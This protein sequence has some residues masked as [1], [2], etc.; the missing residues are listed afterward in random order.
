MGETM[1]RFFA[2]LLISSLAFPN[3]QAASKKPTPQPTIKIST[4][5]VKPK[6]S[7][8]PSAKPSAKASAKPSPRSTTTKKASAAPT[9]T[10]KATTKKV[11][12]KPSK[13]VRVTPSPKPSWPPAGFY[14]DKTDE[15]DVYAHIPTKKEL[16]GV[17][18]AKPSLSERVAECEKVSCGAVQVASFI[19]CSW[20]EISSTLFSSTG[21]NRTRIAIGNLRTL[22]GKSEPQKILTILLISKEPVAE[23]HFIDNISVACHRDTPTEDFPQY[24]YT[25][26]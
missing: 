10:K 20:W 7:A 23:G 8:K 11:V 17:I 14:T 18:S 26:V 6:S 3:A 4:K 22:V 13:K 5:V 9:S 15:N 2:L 21:D 25:P 1:K 24:N 16:V 12:R 19:G